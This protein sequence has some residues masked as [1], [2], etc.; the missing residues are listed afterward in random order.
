MPALR[1]AARFKDEDHAVA[2]RAFNLIQT[3]EAL[4][5][6]LSWYE[7][8]NILVV[9]ERN[10]RLTEQDTADFLWNLAPL[11][12]RGDVTLDEASA[13]RLARSKPLPVYDAAYLDGCAW[14]SPH[15]GG[16]SNSMRWE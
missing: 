14:A 9:T 16:V 1:R 7:I 11:P 3:D 15:S 5:P 13:L 6:S 8:R 10:K 2:D 12:L 4:V